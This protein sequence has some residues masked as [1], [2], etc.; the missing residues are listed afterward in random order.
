LTTA[1]VNAPL[2]LADGE[3]RREID[4]DPNGRM[5]TPSSMNRRAAHRDRRCVELDTP[6]P[7]YR[8]S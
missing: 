1:A 3:R 7:F 8:T 6:R 5:N 2:L 4:D